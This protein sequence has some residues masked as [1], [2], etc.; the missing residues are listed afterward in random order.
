MKN[1]GVSDVFSH[2][3]LICLKVGR[4]QHVYGQG[5][6]SFHSIMLSTPGFGGEPVGLS[7]QLPRLAIICTSPPSYR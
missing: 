6:A 5:K 7:S 4:V 3:D 1:D 2:A